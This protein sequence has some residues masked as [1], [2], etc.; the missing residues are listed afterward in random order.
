MQKQV[1]KDHQVLDISFHQQ[2]LLNPNHS[3]QLEVCSQFSELFP[4][5]CILS[6]HQHAFYFDPHISPFL[7][8]ILPRNRCLSAIQA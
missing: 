8:L 4:A 3:S 7:R 6:D 5:T 1:Y 2:Q